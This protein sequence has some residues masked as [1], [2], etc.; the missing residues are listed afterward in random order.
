VQAHA[1]RCLRPDRVVLAI[2]GDV[3]PAQ[4]QR[5][6]TTYLAGWKA[7]LAPPPVPVPAAPAP[8]PA[9]H[10]L[11]QGAG[12]YAVVLVGQPGPGRNDPDYYA[13][14]L[15]N[16][17]L[18]G[19]PVTSRLSVRLRDLERLGPRVESRL[20]PASGSSPWA[21]VAQVDPDKVDT[22][23]KVIT[24]ELKRATTYPPTEEE[25][26]RA[27]T[28]L[29]GRLQV[30]Q[31]SGASRAAMLA[32]VELYRLAESY[33]RD[34][35]GIYDQIHAKDVLETAKARLRPDNLVVVVVRPAT[36]R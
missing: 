11:T 26:V 25:L 27:Q 22:A 7:D 29:A 20:I 19:N 16:Q 10:D 14:N 18:G 9:R 8:Q 13:F 23:I 24:D 35:A 6:A 32:S 28:S 12:P 21:V 4:V 15:L 1:Q 34:F 31:G 2:S 30:A 17:I 33:P 36:S 3:E 5:L